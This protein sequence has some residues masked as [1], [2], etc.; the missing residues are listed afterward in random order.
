MLYQPRETYVPDF[1]MKFALL[2]YKYYVPLL[3]NLKIR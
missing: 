1:K 2:L 3:E